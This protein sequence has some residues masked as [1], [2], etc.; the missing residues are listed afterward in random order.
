MEMEGLMIKRS[1]EIMVFSISEFKLTNHTLISKN[2]GL[3]IR[4][5]W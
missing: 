3:E 2:K 1:K 5:P 4:A